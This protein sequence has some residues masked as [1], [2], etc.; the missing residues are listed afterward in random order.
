MYNVFL[1]RFCMWV[2]HIV[3]PMVV[4]EE[5]KDQIYDQNVGEP[6]ST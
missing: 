3:C 2:Q 6:T 5:K 4:E 1:A